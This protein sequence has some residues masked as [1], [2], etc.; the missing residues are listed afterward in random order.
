MNAYE[1]FC[2]KKHIRNIR[3]DGNTGLKLRHDLVSDF[4]TDDRIR[5]AILSITA[6]SMGLT[7]TAASTVVFAENTWTPAMMI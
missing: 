6:C 2:N 4:Q 7:L 1:K 3:I 5:C